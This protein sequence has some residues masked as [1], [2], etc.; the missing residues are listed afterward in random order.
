M[1]GVA[2]LQLMGLGELE[3]QLW[4]VVAAE[5]AVDLHQA[6][7]HEMIGELSGLGAAEGGHCIAVDAFGEG[8]GA[9]GVAGE[10]EALD[11]LPVLMADISVAQVRDAGASDHSQPGKGRAVGT[12]LQDIIGPISVA[13]PERTVVGG[14]QK[15]DLVEERASVSFVLLGLMTGASG[16]Q[17]T[18]AVADDGQRGDLGDILDEGLQKIC[19]IGAVFGDMSARIIVQ[20]NRYNS[21]FPGEGGAVVVAP[22]LPLQ[23]VSAGA[24][25]HQQ[26]A[27]AGALNL[28]S[29][30][31]KGLSLLAQLHGDGQGVI[32]VGQVISDDAIEGGEHRLPS[33]KRG[34]L[35]ELRG[36]EFEGHVDPDA[37]ICRCEDMELI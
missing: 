3:S 20:V 11:V 18:H 17:S 4:I 15:G 9:S 35:A 12:Y 27:S 2:H 13:L 33:L 19:Q 14:G 7:A 21:E 23:V 37:A 5:G 29:V 31:L 1:T 36:E 16:D 25:N 8:N 28:I 30:G 10:F 24:V 22:S 34:E 26:D 32:R 6:V